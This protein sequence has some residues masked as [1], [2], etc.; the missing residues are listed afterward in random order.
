MNRQI[1]IERHAIENTAMWI[2]QNNPHMK[3]TSLSSLIA[4]IEACVKR[5]VVHANKYW[6]LNYSGTAGFTVFFMPESE[7]YGV[8]EIL[9]DPSV[10]SECDYVDIEEII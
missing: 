4:T 1:S 10:G 9:I 6:E 5:V 3:N 8:I 2:K 7:E